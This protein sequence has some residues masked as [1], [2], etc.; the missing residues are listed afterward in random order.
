M[1]S[2]R[3]SRSDRLS[4]FSTAT[5]FQKTSGKLVIVVH[6]MKDGARHL[7][8]LRDGR[9]VYN[10]GRR[11]N[12]VTAHPAF[13]NSVASAARL[14]DFQSAP[15]NAG[16]MTFPSPKTGDRVNRCWQLPADPWFECEVHCACDT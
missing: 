10:L 14:Y 13:R 6:T 5:L 4:K 16:K 8:S 1:A 3:I 11:V 12:D 7:N 2:A 9:E 15:E